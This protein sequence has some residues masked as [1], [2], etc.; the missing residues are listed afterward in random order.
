MYR[1]DFLRRAAVAAAALPTVGRATAAPIEKSVANWPAANGPFGNF[2]VPKSGLAII[3]DMAEARLLWTSED[4]DLGIAKGS[5]SGHLRMLHQYAH[6]GSCSG[7]IVADGRV[8]CSSF[9]PA[10]EAWAENAPIY[11]LS[12]HPWTEDQ[13][14]KIQQNLRIEADDTLTAYDAR[15]GKTAWEAVEERAGMNRYMGKRLGFGVAPVW[16]DGRVFSLGTTGRLRA[17][18]AADGRKLWDVEGGPA[19]AKMESIKQ[20]NLAARKFPDHLGWDASL[21]VADGVLV[22]PMFDRARDMGICGVD[23]D[24]G[25]TLWEAAGVDSMYATPAV[26][27]ADDRSYLLFGNV[28]GELR[29]LDPRDGKALWTVGGLAPMYTALS[30]SATH[31]VATVNSATTSSHREVKFGLPSL[32]RISPRGAEPAWTAPDE[33]KYWFEN[34]MDICAQRRSLIRDG[35]VYYYAQNKQLPEKQRWT[36]F[37]VATGKPLASTSEASNGSLTYFVEDRLLHINNGSHNDRAL[38]ELFAADDFRRL[39]EPWKTPH[40]TATGYEVFLETPCI[41][42]RLYLRTMAGQ[43][44]CF[45]LRKSAGLT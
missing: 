13:R 12:M 10:G 18:D 30:P 2:A 31:V 37:D 27:Q 42:G 20:A 36:M 29:M 16:F 19:C 24:T 34:H 7:P 6:P 40:E 5:A 9:R 38:I 8:F 3:D 25:K 35:R 22:V 39:G 4:S 32:F 28:K 15:T 26:V 1:R 21:V 17:Y 23:P 43:I 45:D 11:K 41:D 44:R 33:A 14:R